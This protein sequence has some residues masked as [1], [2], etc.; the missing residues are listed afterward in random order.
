M[1]DLKTEPNL[2][3][4]EKTIQSDVIIDS[5]YPDAFF[6]MGTRVV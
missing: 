2:F 4:V 3:Y 1:Q 5:N 6:G